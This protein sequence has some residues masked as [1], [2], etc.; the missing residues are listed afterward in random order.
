MKA[1]YASLAIVLLLVNYIIFA[2][3]FTWLLDSDLR[4]DLATHTPAP[5]FTPAP[6]EPFVHIPTPIP[7]V[8][9]P[10][11]TATAVLASPEANGGGE[12]GAIQANI[13]EAANQPELVA[14]SSVNIRSGP[15]VS[16]EVIGSLAANTP[17]PIVGRTADTSWWQIRMPN[18]ELGWISS[19]VVS[20]SNTENVPVVEG[21]ASSSILPSAQPAAAYVLFPPALEKTNFAIPPEMA[22]S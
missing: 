8:P 1:R 18:N 12:S 4:A 13:T 20:A 17:M 11:P 22:S 10:T 5:T 3:L 19:S 6:A 9:E 2:T 15:G 7:T 14:P 21:S 16:Y